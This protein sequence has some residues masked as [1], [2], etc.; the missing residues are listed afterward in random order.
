MN[1]IVIK[2]DKTEEIFDLN[3]II[4]VLKLAFKNSQTENQVNEE[5]FNSLVNNINTNIPKVEK[6]NIE[7]IQDIVEKKLMLYYFYDTAKHFISY[8]LSRNEKRKSESY[9]SKIPDNVTTPWGM[10]GYIT[11]KRTYA[12]RLN[13]DSE[14][15][16]EFRDTILRVL[17]ASQKQ[18][19]VGFTN[20]ELKKAYSYFMKLKCSVGGRFLWQMN[21]KTVDNLGLMS[22]QNCAFVK[23]DEPI[24][25]FLWIFDVLMLGTGV[26][27]NIQKHNVEKLP[28]IIDKDIDIIRKDTN[29]ADFIVPDSREGWVSLLEK[30]LEAFFVKG[31]SF[32]FSTILIRSAG[33]KIGGFGGLASGPEDL[34]KGISNIVNILKDQR[35]KKLSSVNCMD[36]VCIIGSIVVSGNVRR[37]AL[38]MMGD[39]FDTEY[40][41][42]K[43]WSL[44]NI[45]NY[46]A[47]SN[48][49]IICDDTSKLP[50]E[51]WDSYNGSGECYGLINLELSRKIGRVKDGGKYSDPTVEGYN[52]C[53]TGDTLI[54]VADG[55]GAIP[56]KQLA[57][58]EKDIPVYSVNQ[59]GMVEIKMG[60]NPR[61]TGEN[62]KIIKVTLDDGKYIKT[63]LNHKF[64]L[65][66]GTSIEAKD[67]KPKMSL[68]RL[69][70]THS[71]VQNEDEHTY[72]L[73][74]TNTSNN[75]INRYYEHRLIA[76]YFNPD[77]FNDIYDETVK[78]GLIKGNVVVHHKDY[79]GFNNNPDNLEIMTF[80]EHSKLHG[81]QDQSGEKNGMYG[82]KHSE[83]TKLLIGEKAKIRAEDPNYREKLSLAQKKLYEETPTLL[84]ELQEKM[85]KVQHDHYLL[86]C[87]EMKT[88]TELETLIVEG[89]LNVKK[90]CENC[91]NEFIIPF[92]KREVCYCS[93]DCSNRSVKAIENRR[94][95][96][97][98]VVK[99]KQK[100][101]LHN[102]I[103]IYKDLEEKLN[104][105]PLKKEW[106]NECK[107]HKVPYRI[108]CDNSGNEYLLR[109]YQ[110]LKEKAV[111]YNHRVKSIEI[112]EETETV[113]N[114]TVDDNHTVG[115]FTTFNNFIGN[116]IFVSNCGE[117]SLSNYETCCLSEIFLPNITSYEELKNVAVVVYRICKH[118]LLLKCHHKDTENIVRK[119]SRIGV[120]ITGYMQCN[121]T[122]KNWLEP[123]YEFLREYDIEYSKKNNINESIKLTTVK[124]SGT[125]SLLAGVTPGAHAGIFKY[126]IRRIRIASNNNLI[127][128]CRKNGYFI[129]Y[130]RNFDGT[131]DKNTIIVEFPS[132]YP[133][134]TKL[135]NEMKAIDQL[136]VIRKLQYGWSDNSVSVTIYYKLEELEEIKE[137]LKNNYTNN[138]KTVSFMLH[139]GHNFA[140]APFEEIT[141][142]QYE[143]LIKKVIPITNGNIN[144]EDQVDY[145][146]ETCKGNI[147]PIR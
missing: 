91:K 9:I 90:I 112:L 115:I 37:S 3:K 18:L 78:N 75:R 82:K 27:I 98:I 62:Q 49:S 103:M 87:E 58:E 119:N 7:D 107:L 11:Y 15:T 47:M 80:S 105:D 57:E 101:I 113:Y 140:Q 13:E 67:L 85:K 36:I 71:K 129:E 17:D 68:T 30:V 89:I 28:N 10:L 56:I 33:S 65:I 84:P 38:L 61:I 97:N 45:P 66:D 132:R 21:T 110:D 147:C 73:V 55:R 29:D 42:A 130:Q 77:K 31:K 123:L 16:E 35:G 25:P 120:G 5:T 24:A 23:I 20:Q 116:G 102:Q 131:D 95:A 106:E 8:R 127:D 135:A 50:K 72:I 19:N 133:E 64:R 143:D 138:I 88:K 124:P 14:K 46:R 6:I 108:R 4:N 40:L 141:K 96:R 76:K 48:N 43:N 1:M 109:S 39:Y 121:E 136:E 94:T 145:S 52:P 60:R 92:I 100:T 125:L 74:N 2:R 59:N 79:N 146:N 70:K 144:I 99:E 118:S 93:I 126:F 22:L 122:K 142:E 63:T 137:W 128:L 111:D 44:G 54:A 134:G 51:F 53:F 69:T 34:C 117:I 32:T 86:W 12:R 139:S 81:E 104:R 114:I 41:N 83:E 26:G